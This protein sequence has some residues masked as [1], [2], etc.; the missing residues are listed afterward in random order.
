MSCNFK[1][2]MFAHYIYYFI[3]YELVEWIL[4]SN[5]FVKSICVY[6]LL[7]PDEVRKGPMFLAAS[8]RLSSVRLFVRFENKGKA[9]WLAV[10]ALDV[11]RG[12]RSILI[13][14]LAIHPEISV[15]VPPT[16][17]HFDLTTWNIFRDKKFFFFEK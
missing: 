16:S 11:R 8:I 6:L 10:G 15:I 3:I 17:P 7:V 5:S 4:Y 14:F 12:Q 2:E 13:L 1:Y 9:I